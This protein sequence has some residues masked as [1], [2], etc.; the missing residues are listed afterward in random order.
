MPKLKLAKKSLQN[1]YKWVSEIKTWRHFLGWVHTLHFFCGFSLL[2]CFNRVLW[3][4]SH[5]TE[6]KIPQKVCSFSLSRRKSLSPVY[7]EE[8]YTQLWLWHSPGFLLLSFH[9][10]SNG[11]IHDCLAADNLWI[12]L[13]CWMKL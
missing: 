8:R 12:V 3:Q 4:H 13:L 5:T 9:Q 6:A 7:E 1:V 10:V 11:A 2:I